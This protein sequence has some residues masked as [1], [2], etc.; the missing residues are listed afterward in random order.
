M[1]N[2]KK[3]IFGL[4]LSILLIITLAS[5]GGKSKQYDNE[6]T[7]LILSS[8]AFDGV[9]NPFYSTSGSDSNAIGLTQLG[10]LTNDKNGDIVCGDE[11][12]TVVKEYEEVTTGTKKDVDLQT[13]YYFVLKNNVKF[14]KWQ[15]GLFRTESNAKLLMEEV[16]AKGFDAYI[17]SE[18]RASGTTYYI[19]L[20]R[21]DKNG[22][23]AER[24][25]SAG[26]DCYAV[27]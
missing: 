11:Y 22:N 27:E 15:L 4:S 19:V 7:P 20:V 16:C 17:T 25:R 14:S 21:E 6:N 18:K 9:F 26:Y 1:N 2:L 10:M 8:E 12:A 5:C 23:V 24:L 3:K 13:T